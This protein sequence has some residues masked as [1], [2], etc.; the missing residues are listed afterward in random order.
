MLLKCFS[1]VFLLCILQS[2]LLDYGSRGSSLKPSPYAV[3]CSDLKKGGKTVFLRFG[4]V[5]SKVNRSASC[6]AT[7]CVSSEPTRMTYMEPTFHVF[8]GRGP[9]FKTYV[10]KRKRWVVRSTAR[11]DDLTF[12]DST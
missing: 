8:R 7:L 6:G 5:R 3:P 1:C 11:I 9:H 12:D 10:I 2:Y 4:D